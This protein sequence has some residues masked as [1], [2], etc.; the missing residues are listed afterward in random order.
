M[1]FCLFVCLKGGRK[2]KLQEWFH[3][4][5]N[6]QLWITFLIPGTVRDRDLHGPRCYGVES[7]RGLSCVIKAVRIGTAKYYGST[8]KKEI[9]IFIEY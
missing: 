1:F 2:A 7:G 8:E 3:F 4:T 9:F 6:K 5:K